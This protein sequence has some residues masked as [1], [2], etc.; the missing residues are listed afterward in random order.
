MSSINSLM[1]AG[2]SS[3]TGN[4]VA[5]NALNRISEK[6]TEIEKDTS[7]SE[8]YKQQQVD[9]LNSQLSTAANVQANIANASNLI[10]G[11][12]GKT[13]VVDFSN[14][15]GTDISTVRTLM[16]ANMQ[17]QKEARVLASEISLDK[18]RG[19]STADKEERLSNMSANLNISNNSLNSKIN[20]ILA[21]EKTDRDTRAVIDRIK[22]DLAAEQKKLDKEFGHVSEEDKASEEEKTE[23]T[24]KKTENTAAK[25]MTEAE[26]KEYDRIHAPSVIDKIN[27]GL[28]DEQKRLEKE[29]YGEA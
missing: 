19:N 20:N 27:Q 23:E 11:M 2:S 21:D 7:K 26:K 25:G 10:N 14:F 9:K 13:D 5:N 4:A 16:S 18:I 3:V 6:L 24:S 22:D 8:E 15:F 17:T 1:N 29:F 28:K 12:L